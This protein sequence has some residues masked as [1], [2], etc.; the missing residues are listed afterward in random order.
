MA[1]RVTIAL[2]TALTTLA[3]AA[4]APAAQLQALGTF[5]DPVSVTAPAG[6]PDRV[7][8]V[9]QGGTIRELIDDVVQPTPF[10]DITSLV[11][12]GGERGLLALAFPPDYATSHHF[13]VYYTG[14]PPVTAHTG[15]I[16]L[17]QFTATSPDHADPSSRVRILTIPHY[18]QGN[19]NGGQ[20][21]FGPDGMLYASTGDG[22]GGGD[23]Q[24]NGQNL[25]ATNPDANQSPLLAK[26]LRINP[27]AA[28]GYST[29]ADNPFPA[30]AGPVWMLG[31]RNP[32]RYSFDRKT[33]DM[34]IG[35]VGQNL[36]EEIDYVAAPSPGVVGG[37]GANFGWNLREGLH[38]YSPSSETPGPNFSTDPAI[39]EPHSDGW[40]AIIGG[41][42]VRDP[43]VTDLYGTYLFGDD[44]KGELFGATLGP[45]GATNV[46]DL[47]ISVPGLSGMGEDGCARVY[48][49][50]LG[51]GKLERLNPDTGPYQCTAA[52][53]VP[54]VMAP[55]P[56]TILPAPQPDRTPP[57]L[58][59]TVSRR[60][61]A[62]A[63]ARLRLQVGCDEQC[64]V[65]VSAKIRIGPHTHS[66]RRVKLVV[67]AG[68]RTT[69]T[70][71]LSAPQRRL[72]TAALRHH[73][74]PRIAVHMTVV[75][76][77]GNSAARAFNVQLTG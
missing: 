38:P 57:V 63:L 6:D 17:D 59:L 24:G 4:T 56:P 5:A 49:T 47:G 55:Q 53:L 33:G 52:R 16:E 72:V 67:T 46:R 77:A 48:M 8:V 69:I 31:L 23:T 2:V 61:R 70:M 60:Q 54:P 42:V 75:D 37:R 1:R 18:V 74:H 10:L 26:M 29:A 71:K 62:A 41:Y 35:D 20:L 27:L 32:F 11:T 9:E 65:T 66:L 34:I 44:G 3:A 45:L 19:H 36:Y 58:A 40:V 76:H 51:G 7:F 13:Y 50:L 12:S 21:E 64:V 15:D 14:V 28:G 39:E 43:M 22:G 25:T 30:P 73:F 68:G